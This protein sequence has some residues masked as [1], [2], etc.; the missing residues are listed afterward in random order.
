MYDLRVQTAAQLSHSRESC[1][2]LTKDLAAVKQELAAV[3]VSN[4]CL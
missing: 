3:E 4:C 2:A 1:E